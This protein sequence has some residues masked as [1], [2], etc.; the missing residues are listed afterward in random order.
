MALPRDLFFQYFRFSLKAILSL[1]V[2]QEV[3]DR[4]QKPPQ[5]GLGRMTRKCRRSPGIVENAERIAP[6]CSH[7]RFVFFEVPVAAVWRVGGAIRS[8]FSIVLV[9]L[10]IGTAAADQ[11]IGYELS[12][13]E[14]SYENT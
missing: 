5:G 9:G 13:P 4:V 6:N 8:T 14:G 11:L 12:S 1:R 10:V 2:L 3:K 7:R